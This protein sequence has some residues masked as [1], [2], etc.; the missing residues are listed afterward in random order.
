MDGCAAPRFHLVG[1]DWGGQLAW[2]IAAR[3]PDRVATLTMLSRPHPAAFARALA[4]DPEQA[5]RSRRISR[6]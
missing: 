1:H 5:N 6:C 3:N 4:E 2:L